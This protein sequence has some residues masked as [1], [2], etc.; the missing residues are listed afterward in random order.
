MTKEEEH[1]I[2]LRLWKD[3]TPVAVIARILRCSE[4]R[5][6][7][8]ATRN[9]FSKRDMNEVR[10]RAVKARY[11]ITVGEQEIWDPLA[12]KLGIVKHIDERGVSVPHFDMLYGPKE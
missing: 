8:Y 1:A 5:I 9:R 2:I 12:P 7:K 3:N 10:K 4:N 11:R 6:C